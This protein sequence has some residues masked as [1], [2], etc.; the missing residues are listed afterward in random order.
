M[1]HRVSPR[2]LRASLILSS[3]LL[4]GGMTGCEKTQTSASLMADAKNYQAKGDNQAALIQLKNAAN[5]FPDDADVRFKLAALYNQIGDYESAEKEIRKALSLGAAVAAS[6][7]ELANALVR[8]GKP[9]VALDDTEAMLNQATPE[10]LAARGEAYFDLDNMAKAK[11]SYEQALTL[12]ATSPEAL[13]GLAR[14]AFNTNDRPAAAELMQ[15]ATTGNPND[16]TVWF[17]QGSLLGASDKPAEALAAYNKAITLQPTHV[18]ALLERAHIEVEAGQ[19]VAAKKDVDAAKKVAPN[20]ITVMYSQAFLDFKQ[21]HYAEA[22]ESLQKVLRAVPQHMPSLLLSGAV[23]L[24]LGGLEQ[25]EK[26]VKAVLERFPDHVYARKLMAEIA[27]KKNDSAAAATVLAPLLKDGTKDEQLLALAG[28]SSLQGQEFDKA[29]GYFG[30]AAV[31]DPNSATLHTS[32]GLS[33]LR[34]GEG[35][36]AVSELQAAVALAPKSPSTNLALIQAELALKHLDK[37]LAAAKA[38][39][40]QVP[41]NSE[42]YNAMGAIYLA[43]KDNNNARVSFQK[44]LTLKGDALPPVI[45][46]AQIEMRDKKPAEA[47]KVIDAFL[48]R[49]PKSALGMQAMAEIIA[50]EGHPEQAV[51]WLEKAYATDPEVVGPALALTNYYLYSKQPEK[52]LILARKVQANHPTNDNVQDLLGRAQVANND[53]SGA[54]ETYSKLVNLRPKSAAAQLRLARVHQMLKNDAAAAEDLQRAVALEPDFVPARVAQAEMALAKGRIADALAIAHQIE[55]IDPSLPA[56]FVFEADIQAQARHPELA[57]PIY[58]KALAL[59]PN[60]ATMLRIASTL[61]QMGKTK[62]AETRLAQWRSAAPND[63]Q[64]AIYAANLA[65]EA[66]QYKPAAELFRGVLKQAPN[67]A[68]VLNNLAWVYQQDKD[69]RALPTAEAAFKLNPENANFADTLGW[70]LIDKG[71]AA[72][73]LPILQKAVA[74]APKSTAYR[75]HLAVALSKTG[76]KPGARREAQKLLADNKTFPQQDDVK[77]LLQTL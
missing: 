64:L 73:A 24:N 4:A 61:R 7:P 6:A 16:A 57:L 34:Q 25:A 11:A 28:H 17:Y 58:E 55:K 38:A 71:D 63:P 33:L 26:H 67:S 1:S 74:A 68:L 41:N 50:A 12:K 20:T 29:T 8:Q 9:K 5:K 69:P 15:R 53:A 14:V 49:N 66:K 2:A 46:L 31:L 62:E 54:L 76:D 45:N 13:V 65:I 47:R 60:P 59:K 19:F 22:K 44:S 39:E 56:G 10:L 51:S 75:Y 27:L 21:G 32:L 43:M 48:T 23:E 18:R 77:L 30:Q 35:A 72:R 52:A 37:A 42:L 40:Q 3:L 70:V 36:K